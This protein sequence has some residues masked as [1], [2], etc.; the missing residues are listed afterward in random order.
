[1]RAAGEGWS[2]KEIRCGY[3]EG[4]NWQISTS[5]SKRMSY[6]SGLLFP[7]I[8]GL[9]SCRQSFLS[10][11]ELWG[12]GL[13]LWWTCGWVWIQETLR[14]M[15]RQQM[16]QQILEPWVV[17][18]VSSLGLVIKKPEIRKSGCLSSLRF[19]NIISQTSW[20]I[21]NKGLFSHS[22][23]G[24]E[25]QILSASRF[26]CLVRATLGFQDG[27]LLPCP[28]EKRNAMCLHG[29]KQKGQLVN[30]MKPLL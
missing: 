18:R 13:G 7:N 19:Y 22:S 20:L 2:L 29:G 16:E 24:E 30:C 8:S 12:H 27:T 11:F 1:L 28:P 9:F 23:G 10:P 4:R 21:N 3:W 26:G 6:F 25:V 14:T 15:K 17:F 5:V